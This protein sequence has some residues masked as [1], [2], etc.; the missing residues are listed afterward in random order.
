MLFFQGVEILHEMWE[1]HLLQK[2]PLYEQF[3]ENGY[4]G[5]Q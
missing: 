4:R 1:Y 5:F 3:L 2:C